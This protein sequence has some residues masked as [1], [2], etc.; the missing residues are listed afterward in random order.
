M[1]LSEHSEV[2]VFSSKYQLISAI[3]TK[4]N[5]F[6]YINLFFDISNKT[7]YVF[8]GGNQKQKNVKILPKRKSRDV[9]SLDVQV[10][11]S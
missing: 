6:S 1:S 4:S 2:D 9:S 8:N 10:A 5:V 11:S 7:I 3:K